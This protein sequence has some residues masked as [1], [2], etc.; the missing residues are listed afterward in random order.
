MGSFQNLLF[1]EDISEDHSSAP[2]FIVADV[3]LQVNIK[4]VSKYDGIFSTW[5]FSDRKLYRDLSK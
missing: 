3:R 4:N 2:V 5:Y 1:A